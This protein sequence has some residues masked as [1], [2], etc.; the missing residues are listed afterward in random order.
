VTVFPKRNN[1]E[2]KIYKN[3]SILLRISLTSYPWDVERS[4]AVYVQYVHCMYTDG[5]TGGGGGEDVVGL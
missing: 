5:E 1:N 3:I 2:L 4:F